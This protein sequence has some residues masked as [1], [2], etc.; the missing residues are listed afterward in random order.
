MKALVIIDVQNDFMPTGSLPVAEGD[1]ILPAINREMYRGY[2]LIVA[3]QD[4]HPENHLSF[5][6]NHS[7]KNLFEV[8]DLKG[9][10]QILWPVHCVQG[11]FGAE[12]H[13]DLEVRPISA[14]FRKGMNFEID[15]YSAFFDNNKKNSTGLHGYL[16]DKN[17]TELTFC[18]LAGDFCVAYS[19]SD[20]LSLGYKVS[21]LSQGI[22]SISMES[23]QRYLSQ[24][25]IEQI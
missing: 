8:V 5:A 21:L 24:W 14:I 6:V 18:G 12:L 3:T 16:K 13:K 10:E 22:R 2:D 19:V 11:T 25:G 23:Y 15:S 4:W 7:D 1:L 9:I 17:V 20:A